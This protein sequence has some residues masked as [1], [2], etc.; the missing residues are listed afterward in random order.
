MQKLLLLINVKFQ[1]LSLLCSD[2][3]FY[4]RP[5][6]P[7]KKWPYEPY[8]FLSL[9]FTHV[10]FQ[11]MLLSFNDRSAGK[12]F[13]VNRDILF[14]L[15]P[16]RLDKTSLL[17]VLRLIHKQLTGKLRDSDEWPDGK[18]GSA[19]GSFKATG[20]HGA[21]K[22]KITLCFAAQLPSDQSGAVINMSAAW[23]HI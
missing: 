21:W 11:K 7:V 12:P 6:S 3:C 2:R 13:G 15:F 8:L 16:V 19:L 14:L 20:L 9:P 18:W 17:S 1:L 22:Q 23:K 10:S 4:V 5:L